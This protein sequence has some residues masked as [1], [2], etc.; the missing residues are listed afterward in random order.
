MTARPD[1]PLD[2][3]ASTDVLGAVVDVEIAALVGGVASKEEALLALAARREL[4]D[5]MRRHRW[6]AMETARKT[7]ASWAEIAAAAGM[8]PPPARRLYEQTLARQKASGYAEA[9]R[10]DP[11]G[12]ELWAMPA[13]TPTQPGRAAVHAAAAHHAVDEARPVPFQDRHSPHPC[14]AL[15]HPPLPF[16]HP[17]PSRSSSR[18]VS[19][20]PSSFHPRHTPAPGVRRV[21]LAGGGGRLM[22]GLAK[23][24]P[25]GWAYYARE[26][27]AGVEDYF[28]GHGEETG[29]WV[30]RATEALGLSGDVDGEGLSRLFGYGVHPISDAALGRPF[31][32]DKKAVA[33]YALSFSPPK[34][35]SVIWAL[36]PDEI[37]DQVR[38]GHDAAVAAAL[39]F[40][41][42]H[43]AFCRRGH[44]GAVQEATG[45]YLAAVFVHRTSRA[46]DPQL[47]MFLW[48]TRSKRSQ[49][50]GG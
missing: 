36:A 38:Q 43:A 46:G 24:A 12:P 4:E 19:Y 33:G 25:D 7:G 48:P 26:V 47:H 14:P 1:L 3:W 44:G 15:P 23:I 10:Q 37:S 42:D 31:G 6:L 9:H 41:Q 35:V 29:R 17:I 5:R 2:R 11:G 20:A 18:P 27:A 8:D 13:T 30:G 39:E 21:G 40:L 34:S 45:G 28:V 32:S 50:G 16:S 22:M 49:M